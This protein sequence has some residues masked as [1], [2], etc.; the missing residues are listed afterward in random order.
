MLKDFPLKLFSS[1]KAETLLER[2]MASLVESKT[3]YDPAKSFSKLTYKYPVEVIYN[4][5]TKQP[6]CLTQM[7]SS[8]NY[9]LRQ[10]SCLVPWGLANKLQLGYDLYFN[11]SGTRHIKTDLEYYIADCKGTLARFYPSLFARGIRLFE[12][13]CI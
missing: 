4:S 12:Y 6:E 8:S 11:L 13:S 2:E 3:D 1:E 10:T 7:Y 5:E 9:L